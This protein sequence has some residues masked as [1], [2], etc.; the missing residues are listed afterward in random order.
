[1]ADDTGSIT[2]FV[3]WHGEGLQALSSSS[4]PPLG[5]FIKPPALRVVH[6]LVELELLV[7]VRTK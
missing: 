5:A 7:S 2:W 3:V 1:M 6:N 4:W